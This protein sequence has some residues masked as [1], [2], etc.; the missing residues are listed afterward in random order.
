MDN[1]YIEEESI[2]DEEPKFDIENNVTEAKFTE[3]KNNNIMISYEK[4][5]SRG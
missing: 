5:Y 1:N 4:K 3:K 2:E